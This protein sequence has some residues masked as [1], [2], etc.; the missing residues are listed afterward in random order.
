MKRTLIRYRTKPDTDRRERGA[1]QGGVPRS[2]HAKSRR[3][4]MRYMSL[5][6]ADGS[7][8]H[9]VENDA[10]DPNRC[11]DRRYPRSRLSRTASGIAASSR[12][13]RARRDDRRQ[14]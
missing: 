9:F 12:R 4:G 10:K 3:K 5:K 14:L 11:A 1:D 13:N 8:V 6:L 2:L 7:F